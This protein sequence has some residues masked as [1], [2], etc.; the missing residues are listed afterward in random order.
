MKC[1][2]L[3]STKGHANRYNLHN[4]RYSLYLLNNTI[5]FLCLS[6]GKC[7]IWNTRIR[8]LVRG[9][10]KYMYFIL[11]PT[12]RSEYV[13]S[14][15]V[16]DERH[17]M[18]ILTMA[19]WAGA[20]DVFSKWPPRG[21]VHQRRSISTGTESTSRRAVYGVSCAFGAAVV[22]LSGRSRIPVCPLNCVSGL[23]WS[24]KV[25]LS[26]WRIKMLRW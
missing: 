22:A 23:K 5:C 3:Q 7:A 1:A 13:H 10:E 2:I 26:R 8:R 16:S 25:T 14:V 21:N 24:F 18:K 12:Y 20:L 15:C 6:S 19:D 9:K 11:L 17:K 4:G